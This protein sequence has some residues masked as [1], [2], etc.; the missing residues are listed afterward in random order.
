MNN[1]V[2]LI[3]M[4]GAGKSTVGVVL[5]KKLGYRFIDSDLIIQ[6]KTGKLLHEIISEK[7]IDGFNEIENKINSE[8]NVINTVI[9]T[10]GSAVY[11]KEAMAHFA[12]IGKIVYLKHS[13]LEISKRLGD[14]NERGVSIKKGQTLGDLYN[15]REPLYEKYADITIDCTNKMIRDIV[16]EIKGRVM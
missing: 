3:G 13:L 2:I 8:I 1:N 4:P 16:S 11:G 7:G 5:A 10:G 9:A 14:L 6:E 12:S 15:E